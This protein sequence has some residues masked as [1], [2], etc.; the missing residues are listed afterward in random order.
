MA[1][2]LEID[3]VRLINDL[4]ANAYGIAGLQ[5]KDFVTIHEGA[6][7]PTGN[8]ALISAG[9]GLGEAGL[10]WNGKC[11]QPFASEGGH[12]DF[13]P[14]NGLEIEMLSFLLKSHDRVSYERFLSGPGLANIYDFLVQTNREEEPAWLRDEMA[15][16]D[17]SATISKNGLSGS[18]DVC[19][20][21]LDIFVSIYA[22]EAAN[23]ALKLLA[24]GGVF[25][26]GGIAPKIVEKLKQPTFTD[27]FF[28]KGR[29]APVLHDIPIKVIMADQTALLGAG[30]V[31]SSMNVC[32]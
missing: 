3:Q 16:H 15:Q 26:G 2:E 32:N 1:A 12:A 8:A 20:K 17:R 24:T 13:A 25:L 18:A 21:A 5:P 28:A 9:T 22:S 6:D 31:A 14:R 30:R 11:H 23:L 27:S 4:E 10:F 7:D 19:V 29:M